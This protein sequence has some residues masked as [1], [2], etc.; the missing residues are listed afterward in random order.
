MLLT[1]IGKTVAITRARTGGVPTRK[2]RRA[3]PNASSAKDF[4]APRTSGSSTT[5]DN[6]S[7]TNTGVV[8]S[9]A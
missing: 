9:T 5:V 2:S 6:N 7:G 1:K 3:S 4:T 8:T